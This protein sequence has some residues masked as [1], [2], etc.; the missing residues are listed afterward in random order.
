MQ[1]LFRARFPE[2]TFF[3]E[4][5]LRYGC[6][7]KSNGQSRF[8]QLFCTCV[9]AITQNWPTNSGWSAQ[10]SSG[11]HSTTLGSLESTTKYGCFLTTSLPLITC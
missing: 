5:A 2:I 7:K 6:G 3:D 1:R 11:N 4:K 10:V 9:A 8:D